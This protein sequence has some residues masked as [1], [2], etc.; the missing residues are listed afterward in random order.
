MRQR[1]AK[2]EDYFINLL[3][4]FFQRSLNPKNFS[5]L[6][7]PLKL[8]DSGEYICL[9]NDIP[10]EPVDLLVQDTPEPPS[11]PMITGFTSRS[12]N[13]SW[14]Q[15][16]DPKN[17]PVTD[18]TVESRYV[19]HHYLPKLGSKSDQNVR[20]RESFIAIHNLPAIST[21]IEHDLQH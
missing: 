9:I 12:V 7:N 21:I 14:A 3:L 2:N 5:L 16:Q 19:L 4:S 1:F 20:R 11:R 8:I 17:A 10:S 13:L 15:V 18:F 6:F